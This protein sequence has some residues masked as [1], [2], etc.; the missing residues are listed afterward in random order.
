MSYK[1]Q[2]ALESL[3]WITLKLEPTSEAFTINTCRNASP[4]PSIH[5]KTI[6]VELYENPWMHRDIG[7]TF[8][9]EIW[10]TN[11]ITFNH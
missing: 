4:N 2:P 7:E 5:H 9:K 10:G 8:V 1:K 3:I 11:M 6:R